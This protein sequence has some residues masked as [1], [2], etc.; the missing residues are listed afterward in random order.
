MGKAVLITGSTRGIGFETAARFLN[1]GCRVAVFCRHRDHA[2][3]AARLLS[4]C[5]RPE[6][7]LALA[8]DV[9]VEKDVKAVVSRCLKHFGGI[10]VLVNNA[11]V[12]VYRPVEKT[13]EKQW[14]EVIDTN[15]KG[16]FLFLKHTLP[17]MRKQAAGTI[18]NISSAMGEAGEADFSAYCASKSGVIGL[19]QSVA[20]EVAAD[21]IKVYAVLPWAVDTTLGKRAGLELSPSE[22]LA[23]QYVAEKIFQAAKGSKKTGHL[24]RVYK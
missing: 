12:L 1:A 6:N 5:A 21:G 14:D 16:T 24:F 11:G 19:T 15:L 22:M 3:R 2:D 17:V 9:R 13:A 18:I 4:S 20:E 10:D 8:G 23:P 7:I